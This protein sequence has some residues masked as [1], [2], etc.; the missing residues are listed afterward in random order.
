[1]QLSNTMPAEQFIATRPYRADIPAYQAEI[2]DAL[3]ERFK[4]LPAELEQGDPGELCELGSFLIRQGV[5]VEILKN[6]YDE[7]AD[8][9]VYVVDIAFEPDCFNITFC[10][11]GSNQRHHLLLRADSFE[12]AV[13]G[14]TDIMLAHPPE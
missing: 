9:Y 3:I 11:D 12:D 10:S 8:E 6:A 1:M 7:P 14:I 13:K 5:I 2:Y 4:P